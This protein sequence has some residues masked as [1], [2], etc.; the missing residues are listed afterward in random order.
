LHFAGVDE[1]PKVWINGKLVGE[2]HGI[3]FWN[4]PWHVEITDAVKLGE[5]NDIIVQVLDRSHAGG[6]YKPVTLVHSYEI[7]N[8]EDKTPEGMTTLN[9]NDGKLSFTF[10]DYAY[11][12]VKGG[13]QSVQGDVEFKLK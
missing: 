1:D 3:K 5:K 12:R 10:K 8:T 13:K 11:I 7:K 6:I 2:R 9:S 4:V